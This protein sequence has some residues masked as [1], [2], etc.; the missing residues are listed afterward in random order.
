MGKKNGHREFNRFSQ[1]DLN[2]I[3]SGKGMRHLKNYDYD[4]EEMKHKQKQLD[5]FLQE[6]DINEVLFDFQKLLNPEEDLLAKQE[7]NEHDDEVEIQNYTYLPNSTLNKIIKI[8]NEIK[9]HMLE[10]EHEKKMKKI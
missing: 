4:P 9:H 8:N 1:Q 5:Q 3:R 2:L 6:E 7:V 10:L